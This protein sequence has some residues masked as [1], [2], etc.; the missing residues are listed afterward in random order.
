MARIRIGRDASSDIVL[1]TQLASRNH[2][3]LVSRGESFV[4]TD[5]G[6]SNGTFVN[7][8]RIDQVELEEGD[9]IHFA[10]EAWSFAEKQ[11]QKGASSKTQSRS[12][13][14]MFLGG[15]ISLAA[16]CAIVLVVVGLSISNTGGKT[17]Q[18]ESNAQES[19]GL[20]IDLFSQPSD[21]ETIIQEVRG[22]TV[23]VECELGS[24][25]GFALDLNILSADEGQRIVTNAHV[26]ESCD[27]SDRRLSVTSN[28]GRRVS[29][30]IVSVDYFN[31]VALLDTNLNLTGLELA[32]LPRQGQWVMAVGNPDGNLLGTAT[33]GQVTNYFPVFETEYLTAKHQVMTDTPIN[34]GNSGGPLVD[35]A[36]R[37]IGIVTWGRV[38]FDNTGFAGGW[39]LLCLDLL[40]CKTAGW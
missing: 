11:L 37:I 28:D 35:S 36:G 2:A 32:P 22:S 10:D 12:S 16:V 20:L 26:V 8:A 21:L 38:G 23:L 5:L 3:L 25:S 31:D 33:F 6:S 19:T 4:M 13:R 15:A 17:N 27:G 24:G 29:A 30:R 1:D 7:G 34:P 39:P 14:G 9:Q 40:R 18:S